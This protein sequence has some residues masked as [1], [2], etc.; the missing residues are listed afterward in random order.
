MPGSELF[1]DVSDLEPPEPLV[2]VLTEAERLEPGQYLH[3][4]HRR[5][6]CLLYPNLDKRGF[7]HLTQASSEG[8]YHVF[9]WSRGD[10]AAERAARSA[11]GVSAGE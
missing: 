8:H 1:L 11:A 7:S 10:T 2:K 4:R 3:M 9:I 6:P 5:E